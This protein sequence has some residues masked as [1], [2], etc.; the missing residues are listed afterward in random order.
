MRD[1]GNRLI[2][3]GD[4]VHLHRWSDKDHNDPFAV[5]HLSS[6]MISGELIRFKIREFNRWYPHCEK[7]DTAEQGHNLLMRDSGFRAVYSNLL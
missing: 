4:Y 1:S 6:V 7:L 2:E 5:G 3:I